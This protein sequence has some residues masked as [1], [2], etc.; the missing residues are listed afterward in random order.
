[1]KQEF[2]IVALSAM[3]SVISALVAAVV[4]LY[5]ELQRRNDQLIEIALLGTKDEILEA[6]V[7]MVEKKIRKPKGKTRHNR[8][9]RARS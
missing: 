2:V 1:M 5:K 4:K 9:S 8:T 7:E 3:A 6:I